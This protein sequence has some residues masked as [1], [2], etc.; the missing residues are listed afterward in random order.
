MVQ[1]KHMAVTNGEAVVE[2]N[3]VSAIPKTFSLQLTG[4]HTICITILKLLLTGVFSCV[5][6]T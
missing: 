4:T 3:G 1:R 2:S 6:E 5:C